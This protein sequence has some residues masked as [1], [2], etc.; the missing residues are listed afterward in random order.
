MELNSKVLNSFKSLADGTFTDKEYSALVEYIFKSFVINSST[1]K[2]E[3]SLPKEKL[4]ES[5]ESRNS[6]NLKNTVAALYT[7][8]A[9]TVRNGYDVNSLR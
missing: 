6:I 4:E 3:L 1:H 5:V 8:L 9:E 2:F 7:V